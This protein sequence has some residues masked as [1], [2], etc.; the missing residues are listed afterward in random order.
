M[1]DEQSDDKNGT[2][3]TTDQTWNDNER[4]VCVNEERDCGEDERANECDYCKHRMLGAK[5][6][7]IGVP[8]HLVRGGFCH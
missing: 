4:I 7:S 2:S 1:P 6:E 8:C 5:K 3:E